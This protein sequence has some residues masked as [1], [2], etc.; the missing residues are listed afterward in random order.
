MNRTTIID[1]AERTAATA[2]EAGLAYAVT[3][4]GSISP[5]YAVPLATA[6]AGVKSWVAAHWGGN[7]STVSAKSVPHARKA[8]AHTPPPAK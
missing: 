1:I 7:A 2:V 4:A 3:R 6:L 8:R 5:L